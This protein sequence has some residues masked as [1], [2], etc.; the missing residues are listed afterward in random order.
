M[1][2]AEMAQEARNRPPYPWWYAPIR[3][4]PEVLKV[5]SHPGWRKP[6]VD[7]LPPGSIWLTE[8]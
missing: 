2:Y 8:G 1:N 6:N 7:K 4:W 3:P 5:M